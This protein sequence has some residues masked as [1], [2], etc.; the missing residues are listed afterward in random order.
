[1]GG[2]P[3]NQQPDTPHQGPA[4]Q[5]GPQSP[6]QVQPGT[7][8]QHLFARLTPADQRK[9]M[10]KAS[11]PAE[12]AKFPGWKGNLQR[13]FGMAEDELAPAFTLEAGP[14]GFEPA[15]DTASPSLDRA[16]PLP[17]T[18]A[19]MQRLEASVDPSTQ[20]IVQ[21]VIEQ[22]E[23]EAAA[24][25]ESAAETEARLDDDHT[26]SLPAGA[27]TAEPEAAIKSTAVSIAS[28]ALGEP[29]LAPPS[30]S[31]AVV[32]VPSS[33]PSTRD[34]A[35]TPSTGPSTATPSTA[36]SAEIKDA[37]SA[38]RVAIPVSIVEVGAAEDAGAPAA[39]AE[40]SVIDLRGLVRL[41][42][43]RLDGIV[44]T[45]RWRGSGG[46]CALQCVQ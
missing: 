4:Q 26:T 13:L 14:E 3:L 32:S 23:A 34:A 25:T 29:A 33:T 6:T 19:A 39:S 20:K 11:T 28:P 31:S 9:V 35:T 30:S 1:M 38:A 15:A 17:S 42:A 10:G 45:P 27:A 24:E 16:G 36:E 37:H 41:S 22:V 44:V 5:A 12:L 18:M 8:L 43:T 46:V 7:P 2:F 40:G 21:A